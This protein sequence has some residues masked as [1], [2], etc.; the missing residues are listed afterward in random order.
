[1]SI[2]TLVAD[3]GRGKTPPIVLV[4]GDERLLVTRAVDAV[5]GATV[6]PGPRGF[7]EDHFDAQSAA[8]ATVV[9]A[10][11]SLPMM[12][13]ARF[14]LVHNADGW[15]ADA[16][17]ELL[18]YAESPS[19]T[20]VILL[21]AEKLN[22]NLKIVT[23]AKKRGWFF[24]AKPPSDENVGPWLDAEARRRGITF[25][26]GAAASLAL[27]I[28]GDLSALTDALERLHLF[29]GGRAITE[30]D[31][32]EVVKPIRESGPFDLPEAVA[33]KDRAR[34]LS[35]IDNL[36]RA[37]DKDKPALVLLALIAR[38]LRML[39]LARDALDRGG[40]PAGALRGWCPPFAAK[41]IAAKAKA[42]WSAAHL[43]R[44]L[45][46]VAEADAR[47]KSSGGGR[48]HEWRVMEELVLGLCR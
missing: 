7:N 6:G 17:D 32:E 44:A 40:D 30:S 31:V 39:S 23:T 41:E 24:E 9:D 12:G 48:G 47:L 8:S 2:E 26:P 43:F 11:R 34:C 45:K 4:V 46:R 10:A 1:M 37:R 5:R 35:L 22:G 21:T 13:R 33:D 15:K 38:Q 29:A 42:R 25:E 14:V 28:G 19:P 18:R 36:S 20:S 3:A 27:S 16:W